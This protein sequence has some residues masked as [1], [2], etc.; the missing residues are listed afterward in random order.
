MSKYEV[1]NLSEFCWNLMNYVTNNTDNIVFVPDK[2]YETRLNL[3]KSCESF[4]ELENR[5][6]ECGCYMP[7]KAKVIFESCPLKKW[8]VDK[9]SWKENF[10]RVKE[11][12]DNPSESL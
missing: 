3:C 8:D 1:K 10:N 7:G 11:E 2:V 6:E 12:L 4:N 9:E 5:C